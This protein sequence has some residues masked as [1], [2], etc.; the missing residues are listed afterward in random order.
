MQLL[1][2]APA[3]NRGVGGAGGGAVGDFGGAA[4]LA[5]DVGADHFG[6]AVYG[7]QQFIEGNVLPAGKGF[8]ARCVAPYS[9]HIGL[10]SH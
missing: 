10:Y 8:I 5:A 3:A 1:F 9:C 7:I 2:G 6:F 4:P